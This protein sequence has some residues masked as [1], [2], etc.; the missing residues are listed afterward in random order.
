VDVEALVRPV[1]EEAGFEFVE[2]T[3]VREQG[4]YT[5]RVT[6]DRPRGLDLDTLADLSRSVSRR[7]DEENFEPGGTYALEVSS[8]GI[9]RRLRDP[10]QFRRAVGS[11]IEV[12][13]TSRVTESRGS[14][15]VLLHADDEG[16]TLEV[17]GGELRVPYAEIEAARTVADWDAELNGSNT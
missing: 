4:R 12:K 6:V 16:I 9:E 5:L 1:I 2:A 8:P 13:V 17:V 3:F 14:A 15:G 7:L 10:G 11:R